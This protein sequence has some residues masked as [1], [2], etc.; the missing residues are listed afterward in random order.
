MKFTFHAPVSGATFGGSGIG[1]GLGEGFAVVV[2][3][4]VVEAVVVFGADVVF[5]VGFGVVDAVVVFG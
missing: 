1:A 2:V 5:V 3:S 4:G